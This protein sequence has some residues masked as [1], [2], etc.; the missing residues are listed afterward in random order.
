MQR[1]G[2][3]SGAEQPVLA[4]SLLRCS[5]FGWARSGLIARTTIDLVDR[6]QPAALAGRRCERRRDERRDPTHRDRDGVQ[7]DRHRYLEQL[8]PDR[9]LRGHRRRQDRDD[10]AEGQRGMR[11]LGEGKLPN[12]ADAASRV[13]AMSK[14]RERGGRVPGFSTGVRKDILVS[15]PPFRVVR[16][17]GGAAARRPGRPARPRSHTGPRIR[18]TGSA[19][20]RCPADCPTVP[21]RRWTA[22]RA[23]TP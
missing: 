10:Q 5:S 2:R 23:R 3:P 6:G 11:R 14:T 9:P 18:S 7:A 8:G 16:R 17:L 12:E 4:R 15:S 13:Q 21:R 19:H 22:G 1:R 20:A